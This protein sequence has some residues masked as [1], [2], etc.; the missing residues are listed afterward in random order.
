MIFGGL[1]LGL[2]FAGKK[3]LTFYRAVLN[4]EAFKNGPMVIGRYHRGGFEDKM[5]RRE[6]ALILGVRYI[7]AYH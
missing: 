3:G 2:S 5:T 7:Y 6:A 1:L 4:K